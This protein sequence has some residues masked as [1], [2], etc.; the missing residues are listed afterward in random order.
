MEPLDFQLRLALR[1][2]AEFLELALQDE[3]AG[4]WDAA[5]NGSAEMR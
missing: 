2:D 5:F 1:H 4:A 3:L